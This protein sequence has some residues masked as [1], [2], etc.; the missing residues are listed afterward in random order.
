[1]IFGPLVSIPAED[2]RED[3]PKSHLVTKKDI[4][5]FLYFGVPILALLL[6]G[7]YSYFKKISDWHVCAS[8]LNSMYKAISLYAND[9]DDQFPPSADMDLATRT[10]SVNGGL[11]NT[12]VTKVYGYTDQRPEIFHCPAGQDD[13][14]VPSIAAMKDA[15]GNWVKT[16]INSNYGMYAG[17]STATASIID[18]PD[19][20]IFLSETSNYGSQSSYD[21]LPFK[22]AAGK[23][24]PYDGYSIGWDNDN[25]LPNSSSKIITRL[26]LRHSDKG[27]FTKTEGRHANGLHA[28]TANGS[29]TVIHGEDAKIQMRG[30][31]PTG[32]W[33]VPAVPH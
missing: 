12:W 7:L 1:M 11:V 21:P 5:R 4:K 15:Q 8:N 9:H 24:L 14:S 10:P 23:P 26:A 29:L 30:G 31:E 27:D 20:V 3:A 2:D 28:I 32:L 13:E 6:L 25:F 18:R 19:Q 22:D 33:Q 17:Y 16:K